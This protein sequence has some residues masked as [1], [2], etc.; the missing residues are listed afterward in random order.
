MP[1]PISIVIPT[2]NAEGELPASLASLIEGLKAGLVRE[3]ERVEAWLAEHPWTG[4]EVRVGGA[5]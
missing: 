3:Y 4:E 1:A 2:L 5:E